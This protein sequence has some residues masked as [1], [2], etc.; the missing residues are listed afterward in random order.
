M[1]KLYLKEYEPIEYKKLQQN[2]PID[3]VVKYEYYREYFN[4]NFNLVFGRPKTDT[5][6][7]CDVLDVKVR[8]TIDGNEKRRLQEEKERHLRQ[9]QQFYTEL[10]TSTQMAK[11]SEAISAIYFDFEQN[12]PL[13]HI[14]TGEV[15]FYLRQVWL[16]DFGVHDC[17][18]NSATM[19]CW[20]ENVA[21]KE[22]NEV[23]SCLDSFL[24]T[25]V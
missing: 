12:F 5:S 15:F 4:T 21:H 7:T 3:P 14:P 8:D 2:E 25:I 23:V 19:Y 16:Y 24:R 20:P 22:S 18:K 17:G 6:A 10:C 1:H 9:A 11:D 13:P